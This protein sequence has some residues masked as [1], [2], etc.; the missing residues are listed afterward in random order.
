M[1]SQSLRHKAERLLEPSSVAV[2]G[3]TAEGPGTRFIDNIV[4]HGYQ[5]AIYP[6]NPK[7]DEVLGLK[8][9][10]SIE[11]VPE[12]VD[13]AAIRVPAERVPDVLRSCINAKVGA[14]LILVAGFGEDERGAGKARQAEIEEILR[15]SN[16]V[17]CGPNSEGFFNLLSG[18][19]ASPNRT[20]SA[21]YIREIAPWVPAGTTDIG[22]AISGGVAVLAQSGGLAFS[23]F[24]RGVALGIGFSHVISLGNELDLDVLD[25]TEYLLTKPEVKVIGMYVEG[26]KRPERLAEVAEAARKAGKTLVIGK[27]GTSDAGKAAALSHTGHLAGEAR[28][29]DA[30]LHRLNVIQVDDQ[31]ELLDVCAALASAHRLEGNRVAIVSWSGGSAVWTADALD[32]A[33]FALPQLDS[34][35]Q[36]ELSALLPPFATIRNPIDVTGA[37]QVGV[38]SVM[39]LVA[40]SDDFDALI[41]ITTLNSNFAL[42]RDGDDLAALVAEVT[43]P[44]VVYSYTEPSPENI[45]AYRELGLPLYPSSLRCVRALS[46]IRRATE[47]ATREPTRI[48]QSASILKSIP[49]D[50][51]V[52][53]EAESTDL[54]TD[55]GFSAP[56]QMLASSVNEAVR[57]AQSI[58]GPVALKLQA[59][60]V[61]HKAAV[62]GVLLGLQGDAEVERGFEDLHATAASRFDD[63]QG[64]LVQEMVSGGIEMLVGINNTSGLGPVMMLGMGGSHAE[65]INDVVMECAPLNPEDASGMISK[66]R[67]GVLFETCIRDEPRYDRDSLVEFLVRLS[68]FAV[69]NRTA[70]AELDIN[71]VLVQS[72]GLLMLDSLLVLTPGRRSPS[73][74]RTVS[75]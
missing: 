48:S 41:L 74:E 63:Y 20:V 38:A 47:G 2:I 69:T 32:R 26:F 1:S 28:V 5:G 16:M 53:S 24:S 71:P 75:R 54:L 43:K 9:Y 60:S 56:R 50:R 36:G 46:A 55:A 21:D 40:S 15:G 65:E 8:C 37:S 29:Y 4:S 59:P 44:I 64:I 31:E 18:I 3:A 33:G 66:L 7:Y 68:D 45:A 58:G 27:A 12:P 10:A 61:G 52:L 14:A 19:S 39:R 73:S 23:V 30:V 62:G 35:R 49:R 25:C 22:A 72:K 13:L 11:D 6:V 67:H 57:A 42:S 51:D 34:E 17:V 70:I